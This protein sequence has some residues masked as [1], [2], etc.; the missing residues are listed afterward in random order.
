MSSLCRVPGWALAGAALACAA[1]ALAAPP[2]RAQT[3]TAGAIAGV[4]RDTLGVPIRGASVTLTHHA[5]AWTRVVTT[6][7]LGSY[8]SGALPPGRYDV[9]VEQL[10]YRPLVVLD[11]TVSPAAAVNL[12]LHL[13]P[14]E[15]PVAR[16]D[17]LAY[18]EGA[19][20]ASLARGVWD[21]DR[22][23]PDI[24]DPLGRVASVAS[25]ASTSVG[26]LAIQGLPDRM[27]TV[28]LDGVPSPVATGPGVSRADFSTLGLP[29]LSLD[30]A[31]LTSGADVEW[32]GYGGGLV[33][34]FSAR[35]PRDGEVRGYGDAST[36]SW[37]GGLVV[38]GPAVRDTAWGMI[39]VD[40]RHVETQLAA[41]WAADSLSTQVAAI[42]KDSFATDL[43]AYLRRLK[44]Q[45]D[46]VTAFG[47]FDWQVA[48]G[49][50][51]ML[52]ASVTN[53][54][55]NDLS[56]GSDRPV[57]LGTT[58]T[59]R[60]V[61]AMGALDAR[62]TA[63]LGAQ[64]TLAVTR[65]L[66]DFAAPPLPGTDL[67]VGGLEAGADG[68]VPGRFERD[69]TRA[70]GAL[71]YRLGAHELKAGLTARWS[72]HDI[73]YDPYRGGAYAFG[74]VGDF[75]QGRGSFV[76]SLGGVPAAVFSITST[77]LFVQDSWSPVADLN[78]RYG[79]RFEGEQWPTGDVAADPEWQ[80][81]SGV[82]NSVVPKLKSQVSPRLAFT[83][84]GGERREWLLKGDAGVFAEGVDPSV[85]AEVLTHDGTAQ[86]RRG[87]GTLGGWPGS[88]DSA[89]APAAAP[90]LTLLNSGF[91]APR[92]GRASL[93]I[94][95]ELGSGTSL[96]V[97]GQYRHTDFL[98]R[99]SDLNLAA[100][101]QGTDQ[102]GRPVYGTLE[103]LGTL[104][105]ATPGS[106]RRFGGFDRVWALD[107]SGF[108]D[109]WGVT[110]AFESLQQQG[111]SLWAS[112]TY[113]RT[114]DNL[115]G[116]LGTVPD[117]QLSPFPAGSALAGWSDGVSDL[118]VPHRAALGAQLSFGV[119]RLEGVVRFRSGLPFTPGF[120]PGVDAN[121]DGAANDPAFVSDTVTGAAAVLKKWACLRRQIGQFAARN[122]CR[123]PDVAGADARLAIQLFTV[124][125][126]PL[127]LVVDG[128]NLITTNDG[129]VDRALFLVDPARALTT[130]PA[131]GVVTVPL[132]AN[133]NFGKLLYR[134]SPAATL[135]AGIRFVF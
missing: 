72:D 43:S 32:A 65:S 11:V 75:A 10:G 66:R 4:A 131:T 74:S 61:S 19:L 21:P 105:A 3:V 26:G 97:A 126:G 100:S 13:V 68:A 5:T 47:R 35:P 49:Y 73:E 8:R 6:G 46:V 114:T 132:V 134:Y 102:Y 90:A 135:R 111:L 76:Q 62:I 33:S 109:Y 30:H 104:L 89:A 92:T 99:R 69:E 28:G 52:R 107:P 50:T 56:L 29:Y 39:G 36:G 94:A 130:N 42:A 48:R 101:P 2:A 15:P 120:R 78:L 7:P 91:E 16:A 108:S 103:Q 60:D 96:L 64:A 14:A 98:P 117:A 9:R 25:L 27:T 12:D 86:I 41:P 44:A 53:G 55:S 84:S 57:G 85:L 106:N 77:A 93:S 87:L 18:V 80:R 71:L 54:T 59:A 17:T 40:A 121:G 133:P 125:G 1:G 116:L 37:R 31:E 128:L 70:S 122:S 113:S 51:V 45:T 127:E 22:D 119:V 118:D 88:P 82:N 112:Y 23:L 79:L 123:G 38:G 81:L 34:A 24:L 110:A 95:R 63:R 67:V 129:V 58:L 124:S 115:P 83:W 20:H